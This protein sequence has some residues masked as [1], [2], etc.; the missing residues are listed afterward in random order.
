MIFSVGCLVPLSVAIYLPYYFNADSQ[1]TGLMPVGE[2]GTRL[3]HL[4]I[5]FGTFLC[6]ILPLVWKELVG[7]IRFYSKYRYCINCQAPNSILSGRCSVCMVENDIFKRWLV[8]VCVVAVTCTPFLIW[9][10]VHIMSSSIGLGGL[11]GNLV[12]GRFINLLSL[13]HI[14][15]PTRPY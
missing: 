5:I 1:A 3:I 10:M 8:F 13:I 11:S 7:L 12:F 2:Y 6:C 9:S 4:V 15:E 14:S